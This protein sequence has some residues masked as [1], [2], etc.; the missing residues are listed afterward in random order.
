M[1]YHASQVS[2]IKV[3]EPRT[4]NH[5]KPLVYLSAKRENVLVY[6]SNAIEKYCKETGYTYEGPWQKWGPYGF[7]DDG[8]ILLEEY[9]P[10]AF[11]ETYKGVSGYIYYTSVMPEPEM[12]IQIKDAIATAE[13]VPV[14][15][16]EYVEDAYEAILDAAESGLIV[17]RKFEEQ[18]Q[19]K[20]DWIKRIMTSEYVDA[21]EHADYKY[22]IENK[23]PFVLEE[24]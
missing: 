23:F 8:R 13:N 16:V 21:G 6:L 20:L 2:N 5:K 3:L 24:R 14:E 10:N 22:F 12:D 15:G 19:K 18:P 9:Y 1:Y 4:S 17:L 11:E 7:T